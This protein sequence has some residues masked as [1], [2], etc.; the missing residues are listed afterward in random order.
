MPIFNRSESFIS[1]KNSFD[2][3]TRIRID[4]TNF[5]RK[6]T[7]FAN[8]V[9]RNLKTF[10]RIFH[11]FFF[12]RLEKM[13]WRRVRCAKNLNKNGRIHRFD[14]LRTCHDFDLIINVCSMKG[15]EKIFLIRK[16]SS[17]RF[18]PKRTIRLNIDDRVSFDLTIDLQEICL[19]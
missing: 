5:E 2:L 1:N 14:L 15:K 12:I 7:N 17:H 19:N 10:N 3:K 18:D 4:S 11:K 6:S 8:V 13:F 9:A 16:I